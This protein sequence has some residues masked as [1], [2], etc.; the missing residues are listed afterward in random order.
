M[1]CWCRLDVAFMVSGRYSRFMSDLVAYLTTLGRHWKSGATGGILAVL[2]MI[3]STFYPLPKYVVAAALL[4]Y[5]LIAGF[6]AWR[7]QYQEELGRPIEK[8]ERLD[9]FAKTGNVLRDKH[10]NDKKIT[11]LTKFR[12]KYWISSVNRFAKHNFNMA[13]YDQF[14]GNRPRPTTIF[15]IELS[16]SDGVVRSENLKT[17]YKVIGCLEG[18]NRLRDSI[19]G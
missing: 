9:K 15:K 7:E 8:R 5:V 18:L 13:Q 2:I 12:T 6:F 4:G 17:T 1:G 14:T 11:F 19:R 3:S 16:K 10:L